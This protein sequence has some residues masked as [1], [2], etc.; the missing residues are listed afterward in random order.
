VGETSKLMGVTK[1]YLV[2]S[3]VVQEILAR[4]RSVVQ[5]QLYDLLLSAVNVTSSKQLIFRT[6]DYLDLGRR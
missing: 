4:Q 6:V 5:G 2:S 3:W 1:K